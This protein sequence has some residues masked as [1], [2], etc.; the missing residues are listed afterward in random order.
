MSAWF[1]RQSD[2]KQHIHFWRA[3]AFYEN[4]VVAS[5][6]CPHCL[7]VL[8]PQGLMWHLDRL[9]RLMFSEISENKKESTN[10]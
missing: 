1:V 4:D 3:V 6:L 7:H 2:L 8:N 10:G 9:A 5:W